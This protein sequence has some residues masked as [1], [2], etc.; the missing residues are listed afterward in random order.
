MTNQFRDHR[1]EPKEG[2]VDSFG[3]HYVGCGDNGHCHDSLWDVLFSAAQ[4]TPLA[5]RKEIP[6]LIP[7][8]NSHPADIFLPNRYRGSPAALDIAVIS[9]L[10]SS[11]LPGAANT[12]GHALHVGEERK[13]AAHMSPAEQ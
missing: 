7:R 10:Q 5:P 13:M 1:Q 2:I 12:E 3:D 4:S 8:T 9:T 6:S 11:T